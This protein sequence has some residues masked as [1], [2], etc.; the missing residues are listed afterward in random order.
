MGNRSVTYLRL[1]LSTSLS[2]FHCSHNVYI[3][4][5]PLTISLT[6]IFYFLD[7]REVQEDSNFELW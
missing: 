6:F 3:L 5:H 2:C 7:L 4:N 1:Y